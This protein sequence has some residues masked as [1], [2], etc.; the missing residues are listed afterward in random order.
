MLDP[1]TIEA[2]ATAAV[3]VS[4]IMELLKTTAAF[5]WLT[6][7]SEKVN[8]L[9]AMGAAFLTGLGIHFQFDHGT[10]IVTGLASASIGHAILQWDQQQVY[11]RVVVKQKGV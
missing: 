1:T 7:D 10:L 2:G 8:R 3:V 6:K 11:Y 5:K 9:V 4:E